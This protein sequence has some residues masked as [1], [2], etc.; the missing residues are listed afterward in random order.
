MGL[1]DSPYRSVQSMDRLKMTA[2]GDKSDLANPFHWVVVRLNLPGKKGYRSDLPW[3]MK[4]RWD[5]HLACEVFLYVDD[6]RATGFCRKICWAAA[7]QVA[8]M[9]TRLG[10][11]DKAV[12][13]TFP[14][15]LPGPWAGTVS[16]TD[17][18]EVVFLVSAG[19]WAKT[20]SLVQELAGMLLLIS[21]AGQKGP[22]SVETWRGPDGR[23][24]FRW[25]V[26]GMSAYH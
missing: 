9:C 6:G 12:K 13:R 4:I 23:V 10:V 5:G 21:A 25:S 14:S 15:P 24:R 17:E 8:S 7:R 19:K 26:G 22:P 18:G 11:Q 16:R 2:Y 20:R 1:T 3:V